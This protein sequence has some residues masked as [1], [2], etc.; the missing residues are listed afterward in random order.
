ML[1]LACG[2]E[3]SLVQVVEDTT[4][5]VS[6]Y[7]HHTWQCSACSTV[8]QRMTF[9]REKTPTPTV[10]E[11]I[12]TVPF[13]PAQTVPIKPTQTAPAEH[14]KTTPVETTA[15][16]EATQT[17]PAEQTIHDRRLPRL[18]KNAWTKALEK[19]QQR[20]TA[21]SEAERRAEFNRFWDKLRSVPSPS[22]SSEVSRRE[23]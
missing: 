1:C 15:L 4:M 16:V 21:A 14:S 18:Q 5:F 3:M 13:E 17:V 10:A 12:Q 20:E 23:M 19:L 7:E 2:A 9:T 6:G 11:P 8:E 22:A